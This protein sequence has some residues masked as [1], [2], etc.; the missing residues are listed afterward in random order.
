MITNSKVGIFKLTLFTV[1]NATKQLERSKPNSVVEVLNSNKWKKVNKI[2][3]QAQ[4]QNQTWSLARFRILV[5]EI[6]NIDGLQ[7][8]ICNQKLDRMKNHQ[9]VRKNQ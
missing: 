8:E 3:T 2:E 1:E 4:T 6:S 5:N 7:H 9:N